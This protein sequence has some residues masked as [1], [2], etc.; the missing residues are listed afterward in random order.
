MIYVSLCIRF[1]LGNLKVAII[2]KSMPS[3][4]NIIRA[5]LLYIHL[6]NTKCFALGFQIMSVY[7]VLMKQNHTS[8]NSL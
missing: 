1:H 5:N 2:V 3:I 6:V 7:L 8:T 4:G